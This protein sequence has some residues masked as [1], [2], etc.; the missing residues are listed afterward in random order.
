MPKPT[1]LLADALP[2]AEP[3]V[4]NVLP[5]AVA[6]VTELTAPAT[7]PARPTLPLAPFRVSIEWLPDALAE[8]VA[9]PL[10]LF[11]IDAGPLRPPVRLPAALPTPLS[12][13]P[14]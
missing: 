5:T 3:F 6:L 14:T 13:P 7:V 4:P 12:V 2:E 11:V 9:S 8:P 10:T 1:L